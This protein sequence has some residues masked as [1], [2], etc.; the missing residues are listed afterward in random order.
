MQKNNSNRKKIDV[1]SKIIIAAIAVIVCVSLVI[2]AGGNWHKVYS[3]FG[4]GGNISF[5]ASEGVSVHFIDVGQGDSALILTS[6]SSVLIDGGEREYS[7]V[8]INYLQAQDVGRLDY[9]IA[10]HPH[11]D[12]IGSMSLIIDEFGADFII[13][14][15]VRE[16]L[17]PATTAFERL[18]DSI[19]SNG[20][21]IIWAQSG[22]IFELCNSS[23]MEI[24]APLRDY[25][26]LNDY[27][28]VVRFIHPSGAFLFTG[29]IEASA[30]TDLADS[31]MNI[32]ADVL[33]IAHHGSRTSS[34]AKFLNAVNGRYAVI[35]V[36]SPNSYNHPNDDVVNRIKNRGYEILRTDLHGNIVF[37]CTSEGLTLYVQ[38]DYKRN[39]R[40]KIVI[41]NPKAIDIFSKIKYN[42]RCNYTL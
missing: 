11:S 37:D 9:V 24:L 34:T 5:A 10:T 17:I 4:L 22:M 19:D 41:Y 2:S 30:E 1:K 21:E 28:V 20:V 7:A 8:V 26:K 29:D 3:A 35:S 13:M 25:E 6:E 32:G 14:P 40:I 33:Q 23:Q 42:I 15:R 16:E 38:N 31:G 18:L 27:S 36:G 12:H 39:E